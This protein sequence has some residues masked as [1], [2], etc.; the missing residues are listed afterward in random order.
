MMLIQLVHRERHTV[1]V[2]CA[3]LA[4]ETGRVEG[5]GVRADY[6][7]RDWQKTGSAFLESLLYVQREKEKKSQLTVEVQANWLIK[8]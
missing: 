5:V 3:L 4:V 1:Q 6:L 8:I 7:I 2:T